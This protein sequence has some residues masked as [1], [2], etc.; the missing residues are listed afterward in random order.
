MIQEEQERTHKFNIVILEDEVCSS[1]IIQEAQILARLE[2][3]AK[4]RAKQEAKAAKEEA[5]KDGD[6][7]DPTTPSTASALVSA[8][9]AANN[10]SI[11][12]SSTAGASSAASAATAS[13][14]APPPMVTIPV[15]RKVLAMKHIA[16]LP[17]SLSGTR[18]KKREMETTNG[19]LEQPPPLLFQSLAMIFY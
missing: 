17:H 2:K 12:P 6:T 13:A 18:A 7:K 1:F 3:E 16:A 9:V 4:H 5:D 15:F 11:A 19:P 8:A 14:P 10:A